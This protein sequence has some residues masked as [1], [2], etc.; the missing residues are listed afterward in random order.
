MSGFEPRRPQGAEPAWERRDF[1]KAAVAATIATTTGQVSV[2]NL[3]LPTR[4]CRNSASA[5]T[6]SLG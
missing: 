1:L 2:R 5:S 4:S 6:R 3:S